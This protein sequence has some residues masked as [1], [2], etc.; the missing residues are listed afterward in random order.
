MP[1]H[2]A[3]PSRI[4]AEQQRRKAVCL[5]CEDW[6]NE[7]PAGCRLMKECDRR[8]KWLMEARW[9]TAN[10]TCL[11]TCSGLPNKWAEPAGIV[12]WFL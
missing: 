6:T 3:L 8:E 12:Q 5:A 10:G 9:R 4:P 1:P 11:R 2:A 7:E